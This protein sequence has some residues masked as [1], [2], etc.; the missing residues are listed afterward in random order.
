MAMLEAR[1]EPRVFVQDGF[2]VAMLTTSNPW[3][4]ESFA[5]EYTQALERLHAVMRQIDVATPHFTDPP[6]AQR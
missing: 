4:L 1:V 6:A 2:K 3:S 5:G